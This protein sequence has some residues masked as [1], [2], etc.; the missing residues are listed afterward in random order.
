MPGGFSLTRWS[1][2]ALYRSRCP[3][4]V[5]SARPPQRQGLPMSAL[6]PIATRI[7]QRRDLVAMC[8]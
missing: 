1:R 6:P 3:S 7:L 4:W 2:A 8:H 5:I